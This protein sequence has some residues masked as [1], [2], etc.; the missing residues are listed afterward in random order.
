MLLK[1]LAKRKLWVSYEE[2]K[3]IAMS[4]ELG[5]STDARSTDMPKSLFDA[6]PE[7]IVRVDGGDEQVLFRYYPDELHFDAV[8]FVGLTLQEGRQVKQKKDAAWLRS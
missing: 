6:M 5:K 4:S 3:G 7:V 1:R 8:E 2:T